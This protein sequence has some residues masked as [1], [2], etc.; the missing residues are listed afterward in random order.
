MHR[1]LR[2]GLANALLV[3]VSVLLTYAIAEVVF[4]R[5]ALRIYRSASCRTFPTAPLFSYK[6][7]NAN[8][9]RTTT[10]RWSATRMHRAWAIG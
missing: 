10:L 3:T 7:P 9:F 5:V 8:T 1:R 2:A 6:A 4:F